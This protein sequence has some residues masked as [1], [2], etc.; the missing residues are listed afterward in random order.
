MNLV[1]VSGLAC[2]FI[3]SVVMFSSHWAIY[4][5]ATQIVAGYP[6]VLAKLH[7]KRHDGRFGLGLMAAGFLMQ[8]VAAVGYSAPVDLWRYPAAGIIAAVLVYCGWRVL[9]AR[10]L[11]APRARGASSSHLARSPYETR[12][13]FRLREAALQESA[14]IAAIERRRAPRDGGVVYL[15]RDCDQR[16]WSEKFGVSVDVLKAAVRYAGPMV[17]DI[18]RHLAGSGRGGASLA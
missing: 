13:T 4:R 1:L 16:W 17:T 18:E 3:G 15:T 11:N 7:A 2:G 5:T 10:R 8:A 14:N 9:E 6:K 12:R